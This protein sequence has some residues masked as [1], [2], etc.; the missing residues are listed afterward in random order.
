MSVFDRA[1]SLLEIPLEFF[2]HSDRGLELLLS[3]KS[4]RLEFPSSSIH[5][6]RPLSAVIARGALAKIPLKPRGW[7]LSLGLDALAPVPVCGYRKLEL[8][9][10]PVVM[11]ALLNKPNFFNMTSNSLFNAGM[12]TPIIP[13]YTSTVVQK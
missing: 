2:P 9:Q 7:L 10:P 13:Q 3:G 4:S 6:I 1:S 5:D 8:F 12:L 11:S